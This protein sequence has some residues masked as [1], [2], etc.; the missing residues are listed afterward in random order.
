MHPSNKYQY[1]NLGENQVRLL[2]PVHD[3]SSRD[4]KFTV[5]HVSRDEAPRYTAV[6]YAW[7]NEEPTETIQ[8]DGKVFLIRPHLWSCLFYLSRA[9]PEIPSYMQWDQIWVDAICI[10]QEDNS[11][12]SSQVFSMHHTYAGAEVVSIWLGLVPLPKASSHGGLRSAERILTYE[13]ENFDWTDHLHE[14]LN[15][16]YWERF[17]VIQE[18]L[19]ARRGHVYCSD[20][21]ISWQ[22]LR[23][24]LQTNTR[25][26]P[27]DLFHDY[28]GHLK[29]I[30]SI[31]KTCLAASILW[32][33]S[34]ECWSDGSLLKFKY[35]LHTLMILYR[36]AKCKDRR[37]RVFALLG[38][39]RRGERQALERFFPDYSLEDDQVVVIALAH[40]MHFGYRT[41]S[42]DL[43]EAFG[44]STNEEME[45]L[46]ARARRFP[47]SD[48]LE[49]PSFMNGHLPHSSDEPENSDETDS[50]DKT[51]SSRG[52]ESIAS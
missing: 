29:A 27:P 47:Y 28:K 41:D 21:A 45:R 40:L 32:A 51:Q 36:H 9:R 16:P 13:D 34:T 44:L 43:C 3:L 4:L 37:D 48:G 39:V 17:W 18:F 30:S 42:G 11:E 22:R 46:L 15:R 12:K 26:A 23:K 50:S 20:N 7:G 6:S 49:D 5:C 52:I 33:R 8:L 10:N 31:S 38:L 2:R 35:R 25:A 1:S 19:L 24:L 14:I